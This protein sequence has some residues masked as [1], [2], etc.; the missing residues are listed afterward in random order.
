MEKTVART[1]DGLIMMTVP[2]KER[3]QDF[4]KDN[5]HQYQYELGRSNE[6][7]NNYHVFSVFEAV[8]YQ[9]GFYTWE[10]IRK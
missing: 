4:I 6:M 3:H 7:M 8:C 10:D 2:T 5:C 9:C 1:Q